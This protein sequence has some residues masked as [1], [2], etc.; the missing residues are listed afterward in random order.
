[1][2]AIGEAGHLFVSIINLSSNPQRVRRGA[3]LGTSVPV[4]LV[5]RALPQQQSDA[6]NEKTE[7]NNDPRNNSV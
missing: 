7:V 3:Y 2:A 1:M 5:Y 4:A 6:A